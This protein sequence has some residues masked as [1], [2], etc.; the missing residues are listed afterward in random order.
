MKTAVC[1]IRDPQDPLAVLSFQPGAGSGSEVVLEELLRAWDGEQRDLLIV[2]PPG[3]VADAAGAG[4]FRVVLFRGDAKRSRDMAYNARVFIAQQSGIPPVRAVYAWT[5]RAFPAAAEF[6]RRRGIPASGTLHDNPKPSKISTSLRDPLRFWRYPSI[7]FEW[8]L[9]RRAANTFS[10]LVAV[11]QAVADECRRYDYRIPIRVVRNGIHDLGAVRRV[12]GDGGIRAGFLGMGGG[13]RTGTRLVRQWVENVDEGM[14][15][16]WHLFGRILGEDR[17][18]VDRAVARGRAVAHGHTARSELFGNL[19]LLV[20]ASTL[21][22]SLPTVLIEAACAGLPVV[23]SRLGGASEIVEEGGTGF[24]FHPGRPDE[25]WQALGRLARDPGL[26][27]RFGR[28]AREV[29]ESSFPVS[30]M[31]SEYREVFSA[32]GLA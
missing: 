32:L 5:A 11:S 28:R 13:I 20:H 12:A 9:A 27:D 24:L 8:Q 30:R 18:W 3:R 6:A 25:G 1:R 4:G 22:D 21:F 31:V 19:D 10:Q 17:V 29:Y 14:P 23:A 16:R 15:F 7:W 2:T 26:R